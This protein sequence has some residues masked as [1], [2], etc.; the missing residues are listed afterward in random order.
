MNQAKYNLL[1]TILL[2]LGTIFFLWFDP[3]DSGT[4][5]GE[6]TALRAQEINSRAQ[7]TQSSLIP[8]PSLQEEQPTEIITSN[9]TTLPPDVQS[10]PIQLAESIE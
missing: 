4:A 7:R 2:S 5:L 1:C 6:N 8:A 10:L 3:I 9:E